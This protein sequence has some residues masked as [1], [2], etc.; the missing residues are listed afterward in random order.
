MRKVHEDCPTGG[1]DICQ[2][3][4]PCAKL[5]AEQQRTT[6]EAYTIRAIPRLAA[7]DRL[8]KKIDFTTESWKWTRDGERYQRLMSE[9]VADEVS[10][11]L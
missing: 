6:R 2:S 11:G 9:Q 8:A 4:W 1:C 5:A 3:D 10:A 7:I